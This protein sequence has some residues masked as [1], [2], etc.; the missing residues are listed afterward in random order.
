MLTILEK[1][2]LLQRAEFF[3]EVRT[4]SLARVAAIAQE[5][6]FEEHQRLYGQDEAADDM[7]IILE[8]EVTLSPAGPEAGKLGA[9]QPAGVLALLANQPHGETAT[10]SRPVRALRIGQQ[11]LF[12]AMAEDFGITRGIMR[13]LAG[14]AAA[15]P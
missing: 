6:R 7:F 14:L 3:C 15:R 1:A 10:A 9:L 2:D 8:G 11:D 12:D 5:I 4:Q 13:F